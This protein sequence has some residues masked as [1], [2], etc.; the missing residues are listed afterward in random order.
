MKERELDINMRQAAVA[1]REEAAA[2][3]EQR[4][5]Q[6]DQV[7]QRCAAEACAR[8]DSAQVEARRAVS[9]RP[10]HLL[11]M[12]HINAA[13]PTKQVAMTLYCL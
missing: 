12:H 10:C 6:A 2:A 3:R 13:E 8:A 11:D 4:C 1:A 7:A 9:C 5:A